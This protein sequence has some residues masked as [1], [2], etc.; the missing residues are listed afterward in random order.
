LLEKQGIV[1]EQF[2]GMVGKGDDA[3]PIIKMRAHPAVAISQACWRRLA[4]ISEQFGLSPL[5]RTRLTPKAPQPDPQG[6][7]ELAA[8]LGQAA[9][10]ERKNF[11][12]E[13]S[14]KPSARSAVRFS[15]GLRGKL[16]IELS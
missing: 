13:P 2:V 5:G 4:S 9:G 8:I 12:P 3:K 16:R 10:G 15:S 6:M 14:R 11:R 1:I 7:D